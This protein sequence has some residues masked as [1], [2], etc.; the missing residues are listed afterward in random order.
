MMDPSTGEPRA[1]NTSLTLERLLY[2]FTMPLIPDP[3]G[4]KKHDRD[5]PPPTQVPIALPPCM[6]HNAGNDA[7][8]TL[9]SLQKMMEPGLTKVPTAQKVHWTRQQHVTG[10]GMNGMAGMMN[11]AAWGMQMPMHTGGGLLPPMM[12]RTRT[13][14]GPGTPS[15]NSMTPSFTPTLL[16]FPQGSTSQFPFQQQGG[17]NGG[18]GQSQ[19]LNPNMM[20]KAQQRHRSSYNLADEFGQMGLESRSRKLSGAG[21]SS[22]QQQQ[23]GTS[24]P[25]EK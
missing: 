22:G 8:M 10:N 1:H 19:S 17:S 2:T 18:G 3:A 15:Q 20:M 5:S 9:F 13:S 7:F 4:I 25:L 11:P 14:S 21:T 16:M 12:P 23:Q 24:P 6:L